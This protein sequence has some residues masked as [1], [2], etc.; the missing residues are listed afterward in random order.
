MMCHPFVGRK[1]RATQIVRL[2]LTGVAG[3]S[4]LTESA[5]ETIRSFGRSVK[6][7]EVMLCWLMTQVI[8]LVNPSGREVGGSNQDSNTIFTL[9]LRRSDC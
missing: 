5:T 1:V 6:S 8:S 2:R 3:A 4:R 7:A 9:T